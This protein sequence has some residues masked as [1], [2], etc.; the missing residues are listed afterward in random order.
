MSLL[1]H[2]NSSTENQ[3]PIPKDKPGKSRQD[4]AT[5]ADFLFALK[6]YLGIEKFTLD[7][8][9]DSFNTVAE[10]FFTETDNALIQD[11][12]ASPGWTFCNPP[13]GQIPAFTEKAKIE[14]AKGAKIAML[15]PAS[16]GSNW[17][18][19]NVHLHARVVFL[20]G[21]ITFVGETSPFTKDCA[22]V[23]YPPWPRHSSMYTVWNWR[24]K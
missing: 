3:M 13:F 23:I 1:F 4:Y 15:I 24:K 17:W 9:A 20:N 5:P 8:A 7:V 12:D 2:F 10:K 22:I 16:V 21:R 19:K 6:D 14:S 11:W 18:A